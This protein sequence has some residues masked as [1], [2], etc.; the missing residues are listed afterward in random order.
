MPIS[1]VYFGFKC[2]TDH[3]VL[4]KPEDLATIKKNIN[5]VICRNQS[6]QAMPKTEG[7]FAC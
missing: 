1:D 4:N 3:I 5:G 6:L 7:Y 2:A